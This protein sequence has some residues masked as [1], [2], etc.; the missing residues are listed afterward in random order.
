MTEV[1]AVIIG[2][3]ALEVAFWVGAFAVLRQWLLTR[4]K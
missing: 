3:I 1:S 2:L 4:F